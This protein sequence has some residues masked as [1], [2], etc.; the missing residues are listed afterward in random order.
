MA[1][2]NNTDNETKS[3]ISYSGKIKSMQKREYVDILAESMIH[4]DVM[5]KRKLR[6]IWSIFFRE[7]NSYV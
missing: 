5:N 7:T 4:Y 1:K 2:P 6:I 3:R